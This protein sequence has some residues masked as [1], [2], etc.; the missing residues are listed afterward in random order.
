MGRPDGQHAF[1]PNR[2]RFETGRLYRLVLRHNRRPPHCF[3][4]DEVAA[5]VFTRQGP[6]VPGGGGGGAGALAAV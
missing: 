1:E 5:R 4:A 6:A 2:L 3:T